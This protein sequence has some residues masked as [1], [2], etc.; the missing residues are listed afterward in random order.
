[1]NINFKSTKIRLP[2]IFKHLFCKDLDR[3]GNENDG[4]YLV[5]RNDISKSDIL[6]SFGIDVDWSF[7]EDFLK[8][9][10]LPVYGFDASSNFLLF[11]RRSIGAFLRND[12]KL[13]ITLPF[14]YFRCL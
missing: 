1:M 11:L 7:E 9:N 8:K 12:Y 13:A 6:F 14:K 4:G 5:S 3:L 2:K 10:K